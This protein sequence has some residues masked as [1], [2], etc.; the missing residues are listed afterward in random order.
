MT[1]SL[2]AKL[3][4]KRPGATLLDR[5]MQVI[6]FSI[7]FPIRVNSVVTI[8]FSMLCIGVALKRFP[9][10]RDIYKQPLFILV[11]LLLLILIGGLLH[12]PNITQG[13]AD[14]ERFSFALL[15]VVMFFQLRNSGI[16]LTAIIASFVMGCIALTLYAL[17]YTFFIV[18]GEQRSEVLGHGHTAF[19]DI[20]AIHPTY[21]SMYLIFGFMFF[22]EM[23]RLTSASIDTK[24]KVLIIVVLTYIAGMI[25]F[26]RS[27][28]GMLMFALMLVIY[29]LIIAK[30]RSALVVFVLFAAG[31]FIYLVDKDRSSTVFDKYGKNV[32]T[33]LDNRM[34]IWS[35][36]LEAVGMK[37]FFGAGTGG[38]QELLEEGYRKIGYEEGI[39]L[40]HNAHN[41]YL[42]LLARNGVIELV[43][44]LALILYLFTVSTKHSNNG[45]LLFNMLVC[46]AMFAES[47][48]NVQKGI[49]F[50]YFFASAFTFLSEPDLD[51]ADAGPSVGTP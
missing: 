33:A 43:C 26:I 7:A 14:L 2:L 23:M 28:V 24:T 4:V 17:F 34:H 36:A 31:F 9:L 51:I 18:D 3:E 1:W 8:L 44:F 19:T 32:S 22:L 30:K 10:G 49:V 48:L 20:I 42:E 11:G 50:F 6:A 5:L 27:Q 25:F 39:A 16:S 37:P 40:R 45:F 29:P 41:Q 35:G 21:L 46:F 13:L 12:S 47:C 15:F 38:E